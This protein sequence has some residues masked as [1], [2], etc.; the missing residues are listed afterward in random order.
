MYE[1]LLNLSSDPIAEFERLQRELQQVLGPGLGR[2]GSIR[3]LASGAFPAINVGSTPSSL[4]VYAFVPGVDPTD[5]DLQIHRGL[6]SIS[7]ERRPARSTDESNCSVYANERYSGRFKRT[8]SLNDEVD[9]DK[10]EA[11]YCDGVLRISLPRR[12]A[13][14]PR[15]IAIQ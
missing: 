4:E 5:L 3:A 11:H 12:E 2:P 14:Q 7:G 9:T 6:L 15:R 8:V 13:A 1:S 10:V